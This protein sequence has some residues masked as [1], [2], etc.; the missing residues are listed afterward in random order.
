MT[1]LVGVH[2]VRRLHGV[3]KLAAADAHRPDLRRQ[4]AARVDVLKL[5]VRFRRMSITD[6]PQCSGT[7]RSDGL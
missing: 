1:V 5:S 6:I 7:L 2:V 4:R 3:E